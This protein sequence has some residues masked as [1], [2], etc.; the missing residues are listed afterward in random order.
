MASPGD[1]ESTRR[2]EGGKEKRQVTDAHKVA[3]AAGRDAGRAVNAYLLALTTHRP[4]RGRPVSAADL[5][6]RLVRAR[7]DVSTSTGV[8]RLLVVQEVEDLVERLAAARAPQRNGLPALEKAFIH[9]A[10]AYGRS[11]GISWAT[12]RTAGVSVE[13]LTAAGIARRQPDR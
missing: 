10:K 9:H 8:N 1:L 7:A 6:Q 2:T 3:L 11:K 13:V 5:E 12:W 4:K